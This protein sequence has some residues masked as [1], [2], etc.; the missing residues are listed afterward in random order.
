MLNIYTDNNSIN[1]QMKVTAIALKKDLKY[2]IY[3]DIKK[4]S[5]IYI[6][7][8]QSLVITTNIIKTVK[9]EESEL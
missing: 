7:K 8:L 1:S 4:T 2:I 9:T 3:I 5:T 6:T